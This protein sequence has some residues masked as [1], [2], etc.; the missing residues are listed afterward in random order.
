[1]K[2]FNIEA[3]L[4]GRLSKAEQQAV[5]R[6]MNQNP[7]FRTAVE[8]HQQVIDLLEGQS[9]RNLVKNALEEGQPISNPPTGNFWS[10]WKLWLFLPL[11]LVIGGVYFL[12]K[13]M[14][15]VEPA[16]V[17]PKIETPVV[18][19][20]EEIIQDDPK[21]EEAPIIEKSESVKSEKTKSNP[22][23]KPKK[24]PVPIAKT[25]KPSSLPPAVPPS[26]VRGEKKET[27]WNKFIESIWWTD[28][29]I[30]NQEFGDNFSATAELLKD[31]EYEMAFVQLRRL[32]RKL[33]Q[34]D[35]LLFLKGYCFTQLKEGEQAIKSFDKIAQLPP[36]WQQVE[37]A[38]RALSLLLMGKPEAAKP[39]FEKITSDK[40][41]PFFLRSKGIL[42][43]Y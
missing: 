39:L 34:N 21:K 17:S 27:E 8:D 25:E 24:D 31:Q 32:E 14:D 5:E 9:V 11:F 12:Q 30:E 10:Q 3:Y 15:S 2:N 40:E 29:P 20:K 4:E 16:P 22:P 1:M 43:K 6:E 13:S 37:E 19:L 36:N 35:T 23:P 33:P 28:L 26:N 42:D 41:H 7:T 38:Y 18:P